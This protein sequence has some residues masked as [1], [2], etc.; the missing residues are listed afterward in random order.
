[1]LSIKESD[2]FCG[3]KVGEV[4]LPCSCDSPV[5]ASG[6]Q[7]WTAHLGSRWGKPSDTQ[8]MLPG[9]IP[10]RETPRAWKMR[11]GSRWVIS[12]LSF[13][14]CPLPNLH[15]KEVRGGLIGHLRASGESWREPSPSEDTQRATI[16]LETLRW[17]AETKPFTTCVHQQL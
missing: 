7:G 14:K 4:G 6:T 17:K 12:T 11:E 8:H 2:R 15:L 16:I 10:S 3:T 5:S 1:M 13:P 9:P